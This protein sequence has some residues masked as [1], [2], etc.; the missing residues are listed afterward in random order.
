VQSLE[1]TLQRRT[2]ETAAYLGPH[3]D[4][5]IS[6]TG[7][8]P[9]AVSNAQLVGTETKTQVPWVTTAP[10]RIS[11]GESIDRPISL[12]WRQ[13]RRLR[14]DPS[15]V[16]ELETAGG[17]RIHSAAVATAGIETW[18]PAEEVKAAL[19]ALLLGVV[20]WFFP[21]WL[22]I[23][24]PAVVQLAAW[25]VCA[26][27]TAYTCLEF[28]VL[29]WRGQPAWGT[30]LAIGRTRRI[31]PFTDVVLTSVAVCFVLTAPFA[32]ATFMLDAEG[33]EGYLDALSLYAWHAFDVLPFVNATDTLNWAEPL[34]DH[35]TTTG[36]L[37]LL[38]KGLVLAPVVAAARAAWQARRPDQRP[39]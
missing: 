34:E 9:V 2:Q 35:S 39:R 33:R 5:L 7:A 20:W 12:T 37:L 27:G 36:I 8:D 28:Y 21:W 13:A 19:G 31:R 30:G 11:A 22:L 3:L 25:A 17:E 26:A 29:L 4:A 10:K 38:Y 14:H 16:L 1:L 23:D 24:A 32:F 18:T 6:N 15:L